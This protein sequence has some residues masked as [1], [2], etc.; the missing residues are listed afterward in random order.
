MPGS[1]ERGQCYDRIAES[2]NAVKDGYF[3]LHPKALR[4]TIK[5]LPKFACQ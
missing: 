3:K 2:L 1:K 5:K 4:D